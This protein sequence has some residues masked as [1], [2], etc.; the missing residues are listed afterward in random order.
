MEGQGVKESER[1]RKCAH[2][3]MQK[4]ERERG[5]EGKEREYTKLVNLHIQITCT[6]GIHELQVGSSTLCWHFFEHNR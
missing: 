4:G 5:R 6:T 1:V 2:A 3:H